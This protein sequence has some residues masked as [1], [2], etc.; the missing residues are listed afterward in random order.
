[1]GRQ[2][3]N[4]INTI[5]VWMAHCI[6]VF[7]FFFKIV[8]DNEIIDAEEHIQYCTLHSCFFHNQKGHMGEK[9]LSLG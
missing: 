6:T 5:E 8:K 4:Y 9:G 7:F 3:K 2:F 1:V